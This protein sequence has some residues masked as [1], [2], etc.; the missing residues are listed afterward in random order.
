V[1]QRLAQKTLDPEALIAL[2]QRVS[3]DDPE[4]AS[5]AL[6]RAAALL[7]AV[8][9]LDNR[10]R[11]IHILLRVQHQVDGEIDPAVFRLG[12]LTV[13]ELRETEQ[14]PPAGS[15][16]QRPAPSAPKLADSLETALVSEYAR[17]D[18][19]AA[20]TFARTLSDGQRLITLV[21]ITDLLRSSF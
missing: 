12:F 20:L 4:L 10:A 13:D 15:P 17:V 1:R 11:Q 5:L 8:Q 9:P 3:G 18:F 16:E 6:E 19:D 7:P 14:A 21:Q 2:A